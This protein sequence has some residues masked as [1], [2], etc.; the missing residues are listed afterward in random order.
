[1]NATAKSTPLSFGLGLGFS[2]V[3]RTVVSLSLVAAPL[4]T[5][6]PTAAHASAVER[7]D[8]KVHAI[9]ASKSEG[10]ARVPKDLAF[11]K[12]QLGDDQFAAYRSFRL[13]ESHAAP[14][15]LKT[16]KEIGLKTGHRVGLELLGGTSK[17]LKLHATLRARSSDKTLVDTDYGIE[18]GGVLLLGGPKFKDG[19]LLFA[20]ACRG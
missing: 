9:H 1:M 20:I 10:A 15:K 12:D 14:L 8:C 13:L 17:R 2:L 18:S 11:L 19:V 16:P 7:A 5:L 6:V 3:A 4:L